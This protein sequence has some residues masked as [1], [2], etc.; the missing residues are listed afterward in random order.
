MNALPHVFG[1][2]IMAVVLLRNLITFWWIG[3]RGEQKGA[4]EMIQPPGHVPCELLPQGRLH[5]LKLPE[6][7]NITP[8][9]GDQIVNTWALGDISYWSHVIPPL[10]HKSSQLSH[11]AKCFYSISKTL[12]SLSSYNIIK[13]SKSRAGGMTQVVEWLPSKHKSLSS[14]QIL[15]LESLLRFKSNFYLCAQVKS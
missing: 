2:K 15:S 3:N 13:K 6:S 1:Q 5:L 14:K 10:T 12:Q 9:F 8:L 7:S 4:W 11:N